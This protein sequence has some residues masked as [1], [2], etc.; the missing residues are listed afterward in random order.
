MLTAL[1]LITS[2]LP[3]LT[4]KLD[5]GGGLIFKNEEELVQHMIRLAEDSPFR[6]KLGMEGRRVAQERYVWD[7]GSFVEKYVY[8]HSEPSTDTEVER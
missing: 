8:E 1:P 2:N 7:T 5:E 6:R 4:E 3:I